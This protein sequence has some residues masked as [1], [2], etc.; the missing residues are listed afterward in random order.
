MPRILRFAPAALLLAGCAHDDA[1][2]R[3]VDAAPL[4]QPAMAQ[5]VEGVPPPEDT[6]A[7]RQVEEQQEADA[8]RDLP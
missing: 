1:L 3:P 8:G 7:G 2:Y 5:P 4:P 6:G